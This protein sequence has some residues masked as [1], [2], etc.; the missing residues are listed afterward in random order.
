MRRVLIL[1][2]SFPPAGGSGVQRIAKFVKYLPE[3]GWAS[4]VLTS[5][6]ES[7]DLQDPSLLDEIPPQAEVVR[8]Q[9]HHRFK[10]LGRTRWGKGLLRLFL[11][12]DLRA[13]WKGIALQRGLELCRRAPYDAILSTDP[14]TAH[15]VGYSLH[16]KT[17]IPWVMD[18]RDLWTGAF[19]YRPISFVHGLCDAALERRLLT[20]AQVVACA[21]HGY[22]RTLLAQYPGLR[23][24]GLT[25]ITNGYDEEDFQ[26][27]TPRP[28][29]LFVLTHV[30][31]LYDF[32][33]RPRS[34]GW[35]RFLEP[36]ISEVH[37]G[38]EARSP[39][40]LLEAVRL[41]LN[42]HPQAWGRVRVRFIG[43][44]P[45]VFEETIHEFGLEDVVERIGYLPH[46]EAL[47]HMFD[48][49][50][51]FLMQ[52]GEGSQVVVPAK[53]YEYLRSGNA[54][55]GML[56]GGEAADIILAAQAGVVVP[57]ADTLAIQSAISSWYALWES[58]QP[59]IRPRWEIVRAYTRRQKAAE[60]AALLD[61]MG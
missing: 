58:G 41:F 46:R 26:G 16:R 9:E 37:A 39:R 2:Y 17:G 59:L 27:L 25:V 32:A 14:A 5:A 4:T 15:W 31:Q 23:E 6:P 44:F 7:F 45:S 56:E 36:L 43:R 28:H 11:F 10:I 48:T 24:A 3:Y 42:H 57:P 34:T 50:V 47:R 30:G 49:S 53:L 18:V 19:Y 21:T 33:V 12:P 1:S 61:R 8:T 52:A 29:E 20:S 35:S 60:L 51:V 38:V 22:K 54:I 55:L 40:K 13:T